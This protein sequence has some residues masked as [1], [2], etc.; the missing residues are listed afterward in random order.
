MHQF[1]QLPIFQLPVS[2]P[3][4]S[5]P[6]ISQ[7]PISQVPISNASRRR[8]ARHLVG[9]PVKDIERD[10]VLETLASTDGN[11]TTSARLLGMSVRTL[12]KKITEYSADGLEVTPRRGGSSPRG[13]E[14]DGAQLSFAGTPRSFLQQD[15]IVGDARLEQTARDALRVRLRPMTPRDP[16]VSS[17][18]SLNAERSSAF[19]SKLLRRLLSALAAITTLFR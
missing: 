16:V 15:S 13:K 4:I 17:D 5:Q 7:I 11:R 10:L 2:Q 18:L 6:P 12:R 1:P 19:G 9:L 8:L 3:P 14:E